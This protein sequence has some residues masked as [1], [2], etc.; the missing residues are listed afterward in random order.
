MFGAVCVMP[1]SG[2]VSQAAASELPVKH[3]DGPVGRSL[4]PEQKVLKYQVFGVMHY[5]C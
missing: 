3:Q 2:R 4:H 5:Q 1:V